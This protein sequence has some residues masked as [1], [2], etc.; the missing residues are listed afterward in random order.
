MAKIK[1]NYVTHGISGKIGDLVFKYNKFGN[2][3]IVVSKVVFV[4]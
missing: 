3:C 2:T 4:Y 1:D